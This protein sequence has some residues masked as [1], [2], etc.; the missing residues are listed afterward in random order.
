MGLTAST[1]PDAPSDTET[2]VCSTYKPLYVV[3]ILLAAQACKS[4]GLVAPGRTWSALTASTA[5]GVP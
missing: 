3:V 5:P 4:S 1:A 2:V